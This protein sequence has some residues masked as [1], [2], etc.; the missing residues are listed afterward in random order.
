MGYFTA[1][2]YVTPD[3]Y[4]LRTLFA[5]LYLYKTSENF[6]VVDAGLP[7]F[8]GK[9]IGTI[10]DLCDAGKPDAV[11]LTHGH[12]DHIGALKKICRRWPAL[13]VYAH[14]LEHPYLNG[15]EN[16]TK[17][18]PF[19]GKGAMAAMSF[20]YPRKP[21]DISANLRALPEDGSVPHMPGW[22][23]VLTPGHTRG[24]IALFR[25]DDRCLIAGDA[26]VTTRQESLSHVL[27]Q[28]PELNG[29]PAY[30]T[31][32][33][34]EAENSVRKLLA[35]NPSIAATGHGKPVSGEPLT[36]SLSRLVHGFGEKAVPKHGRYAVLYKPAQPAQG[37]NIARE[38][39][40]WQK[41][42]K[43]RHSMPGN[44][45][46]PDPAAAP[47]GTDQEAGGPISTLQG[48]RRG[49]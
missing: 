2:D 15:T 7:G 29:P 45:H 13:P 30:F 43:R 41:L 33:W 37:Q 4:R 16:Y 10:E 21:I 17:P 42:I 34:N 23:W 12:F 36:Q 25:D 5:N 49:S 3:L 44:D 27:R 11:I 20:L 31:P 26:F 28:S 22:Q 14:P 32:D 38:E 9:V 19:V 47:L 1:V 24:H 46:A 39:G 35:L 18:D 48:N 8:G 6:V 40:A